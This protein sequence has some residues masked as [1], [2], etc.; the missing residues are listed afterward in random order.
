LENPRRKRQAKTIRLFRR[1]HRLSAISLFFFFFIIS[2]SGLLL[3]WKKHSAGIILPKTTTGT[4][5]DFNDWLPLDSLNN[6]ANN[7]LLEHTGANLSLELDRVD[8]RKEKG[9]AKFVYAKHYWGVQVDGAT[10]KV[11]HIGKRNSDLFENIHDGSILD[12]LLGTSNGQIK[13]FYSTVMAL[14]L[15]TFTITGFWLWYG[16]KRMKAAVRHEP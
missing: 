5:T 6:I 15:L 7:A 3:G 1:V 10:G 16:P 4:S 8:I 14:S 13:L 11:L 12:R 2:C 9:V